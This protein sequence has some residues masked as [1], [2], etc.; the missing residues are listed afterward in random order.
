MELEQG[1]WK[2]VHLCRNGDCQPKDGEIHCC[3]YAA[4]DSA[5]CGLEELDMGG[6]EMGSSEAAAR[7][8]TEAVWA[9]RCWGR[10]PASTQFSKAGLAEA[11]R[12]NVGI[13]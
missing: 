4:L 11:N 2:W 1:D 8:V 13:S 12:E 10:T 3:E 6:C 7:T 9:D 5:A